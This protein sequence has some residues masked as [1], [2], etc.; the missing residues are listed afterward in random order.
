MLTLMIVAIRP[1]MKTAGRRSMEY[2]SCSK[3]PG[4]SVVMVEPYNA[5]RLSGRPHVQPGRDEPFDGRSA[6]TAG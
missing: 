6:P 4:F 2:F 5:L 3:M 1:M